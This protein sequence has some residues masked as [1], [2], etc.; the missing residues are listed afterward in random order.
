MLR[1]IYSG[2]GHYCYH[3]HIGNAMIRYCETHEKIVPDGFVSSVKINDG[4]GTN[5]LIPM[6]NACPGY[7]AL[8]RIGPEGIG[9]LDRRMCRVEDY[10]RR[11]TGEK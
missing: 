5:T 8:E 2:Y 1:W 3:H 10:A 4:T 11:Y 7:G 9:E 6:P